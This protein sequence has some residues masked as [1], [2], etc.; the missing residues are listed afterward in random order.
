MAAREVRQK[1]APKTT[2]NM[3]IKQK[4][5]I[6][7]IATDYLHLGKRDGLTENGKVVKPLSCGT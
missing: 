5:L 6:Q 3:E 1:P 2:Y 4:Q 7:K